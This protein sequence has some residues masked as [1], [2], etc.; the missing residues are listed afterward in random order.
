MI[1]ILSDYAENVGPVTPQTET[2]TKRRSRRSEL[3]INRLVDRGDFSE[4]NAKPIAK[5]LSLMTKICNAYYFH[6]QRPQPVSP[7]RSV[8]SPN[9]EG[10]SLTD[11]LLHS[12]LDETI[13]SEILERCRVNSIAINDLALAL[14]FQVCHQWNEQSGIAS[15]STRMR[16]LMPFDLRGRA[17]MN[18]PATNRLSFAF[19]GRTH[20]QCE[21]W[22][23][24]LASVQ[25]ETQSIKESRVYMDF[26]QG[27]EAVASKPNWMRRF[28][29]W[30]S[31]M[32]TSVLTYTGDI[33]RG[34]KNHFPEENGRRRI[35]DTYLENVLIAPPARRNTNITFG[36]CINWGKVCI[37]ANWNRTT[38]SASDCRA[39]LDLYTTAWRKWL[40]IA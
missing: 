25:A 37:S 15:R 14:L 6:F 26:L 16:L 8:M 38:L 9:A 7:S 4:I 40:S 1:D 22:D 11:P 18:L 27:L 13:S 23:A 12:V 20:A 24:L 34:M 36:L 35:G 39:F 33:S 30:S 3:D 29:K 19:L 28:V 2:T 31:N 32:S 17:D 21:N 5:P 10:I